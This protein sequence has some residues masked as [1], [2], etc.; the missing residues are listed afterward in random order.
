LQR[1][2]LLFTDMVDLD[3]KM[4]N[5]WGFSAMMANFR[6]ASCL[7]YPYFPALVRTAAMSDEYQIENT[8]SILA[9]YTDP[10]RSKPNAPREVVAARYELCD[11]LA[12]LLTQKSVEM[13]LGQGLTE[14]GVLSRSY[15][16][17]T[18]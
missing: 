4:N 13:Q 3:Q 15:K 10:G 8:L 11:H 17:T 6:H 14:S 2:L 18:L 1:A 7:V 16:G 5:R 12:D 9:L